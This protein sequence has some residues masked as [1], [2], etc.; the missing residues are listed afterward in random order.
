MPNHVQM[1]LWIPEKYAV[2]QIVVC[3]TR[4]CIDNSVTARQ[5]TSP[6]I[7]RCGSV[8][9]CAL[10]VASMMLEVCQFFI[11]NAK[12]ASLGATAQ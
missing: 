3:I 8:S 5:H 12:L 9:V 11:Y 4:S 7:S 10:T 6:L 2:S 1:M